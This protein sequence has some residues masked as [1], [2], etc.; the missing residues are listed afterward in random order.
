MLKNTEKPTITVSFNQ[1]RTHMRSFLA[2]AGNGTVV[3]VTYDRK[4]P[5]ALL[6]Q[7]SN[8]DIANFQTYSEISLS[9]SML[10]LRRNFQDS[11]TNKDVLISRRDAPKSPVI[12]SF[13]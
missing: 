4:E 10:N 5:I 9:Q 11:G 8:K 3:A 2:T 1:F 6:R 13:L 12:L 7:K